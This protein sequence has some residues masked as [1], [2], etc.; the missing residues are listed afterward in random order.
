MEFFDFYCFAKPIVP[1]LLLCAIWQ[2]IVVRDVDFSADVSQLRRAWEAP[3]TPVGVGNRLDLLS[4][5]RECGETAV[6][7]GSNGSVQDFRLV[8][9]GKDLVAG[10]PLR[11]YGLG[12]GSTIHMLGRLRGGA[13]LG[14]VVKGR[15]QVMVG[16]YIEVGY[17][18]HCL[19]GISP[20]RLPR[21]LLGSF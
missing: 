13:Q 6:G 1:F 15:S 20:P 12:Q 4:R 19:D 11:E 8:F 17:R 14:K 10:E 5:T 21:T 3:L 2:P 9:A 16:W 18:V 7:G